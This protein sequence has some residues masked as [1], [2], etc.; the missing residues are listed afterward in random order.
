MLRLLSRSRSNPPKRSWRN[1]EGWLPEKP[2]RTKMSA[3]RNLSGRRFG[4][5]TVT[6]QWESRWSGK[7]KR[8]LWLCRCSCGIST[9]VSGGHLTTGHTLSCG[10]LQRETVAKT[11]HDLT[12]Q[13]FGRLTVTDQ[14]RIKR[15]GK[16]RHAH[17]LCLCECGNNIW[18][19]S[20]HLVNGLTTSCG[21]FR[22]ETQTRKNLRH[23][24]ARGGSQ[25]RTYRSWKALWTRATNRKLKSAHR[26]VKRGI[27]VDPRWKSFE[28]FL[29]DM[30]ERPL[31]TSIHRI[32][33]NL[34]YSAENC[35]WE[36]P[37]GQNRNRCTTKLTFDAAV[38][39]AL[40]VFRG[41]QRKVIAHDYAISLTTVYGIATGRTWQ[42]AFLEAEAIH[43]GFLP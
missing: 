10:C 3:F 16:Q 37:S 30:G 40:R 28:T 34:G 42:D 21:C 18:V 43:G 27:T 19:S 13:R 15:V 23:G 8:V 1:Y 9:W 12:G 36:T 4:R 35:R 17:W 39:I 2:L 11:R 22:K 29:A 38:E 24:H 6:D 41:E 25:S 7:H 20:N 32:N 33:D 14:R 31:G 5:L 26:Y